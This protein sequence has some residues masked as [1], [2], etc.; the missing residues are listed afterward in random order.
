MIKYDKE[1]ISKEIYNLVKK[2][3]ET[4]LNYIKHFFTLLDLDP[5]L[6]NHLYKIN[7]FIDHERFLLNDEQFA[8][9]YYTRGNEIHIYKSFIE[10]IMHNKD[11][12]YEQLLHVLSFTLT[13]EYM[14]A[15]RDIY[16]NDSITNIQLLLFNYENKYEEFTQKYGHLIKMKRNIEELSITQYKDH[17]DI[18]A[19]DHGN[20][21]FKIYRINNDK[22]YNK[23]EIHRIINSY[24]LQRENDCQF[25]TSYYNQKSSKPFNNIYNAPSFLYNPTKNINSL[26][27]DEKKAYERTISKQNSMEEILI[28][29]VAYIILNSRNKDKLDLN[30]T[31]EYFKAYNNNPVLNIG[32]YLFNEIGEEG[33]KW[34]ILSCYMEEY[35]DRLKEIYDSKYPQ[36]LTKLSGIYKS[37]F[38]GKEISEN[39]LNTTKRLLRIKK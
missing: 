35:R 16:L 9:F 14:H 5:E 1:A 29:A 15:N 31:Y 2:A 7:L 18:I 39:R 3:Q 36:I 34:F 17:T 27:R 30:A 12:N 20:N 24:P 26:N 19:Y 21:F 22:T 4:S 13:H 10:N 28:D 6:F 33:L 8:A 11:K 32:L 37:E 25:I 23:K 38:N